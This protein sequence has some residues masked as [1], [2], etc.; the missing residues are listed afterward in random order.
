MKKSI[1]SVSIVIVFTIV[2]LFFIRYSNDHKECST[3]TTIT[4]DASGN[5]VQESKHICREKFS[6]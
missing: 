1:Y 5:V 3:E 6:F 2:G 4:K